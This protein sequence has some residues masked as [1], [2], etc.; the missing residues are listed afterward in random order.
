MTEAELR[1]ITGPLRS[2]LRQALKALDEIEADPQDIDETAMGRLGK[3]TFLASLGA[4][5]LSAQAIPDSDWLYAKGAY[6]ILN[7]E[8]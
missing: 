2:H 5:S 4:K 3:L 8:N 6:V 7:S 1:T